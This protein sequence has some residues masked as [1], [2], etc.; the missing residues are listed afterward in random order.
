LSLINIV[1]ISHQVEAEQIGVERSA[2]DAIN[3]DTAAMKREHKKFE[4]DSKT[5][6]QKLAALESEVG[7]DLGEMKQK[8]QFTF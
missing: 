4:S 7:K 5:M 2:V 6:S 8:K 3:R 1:R